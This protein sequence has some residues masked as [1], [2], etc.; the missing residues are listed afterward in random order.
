MENY[1]VPHR[2]VL[3]R[4]PIDGITSNRG[5]TQTATA[6]SADSWQTSVAR[7]LVQAPVERNAVNSGLKPLVEQVTLS[8]EG[9]AATGLATT[10]PAIDIASIEEAEKPKNRLAAGRAFRR[11][12]LR[13]GLIIFALLLGVGGVLFAQGYSKVH[14]VFK[15]TAGHAAALQAHVDPKLLKGE[16]DGRVNILL[17]GNGG[18]GHDAPDLTDTLLV[19]S[20]DPVNKTATLLSIPRDLWVQVPNYGSMKINAAYEV[21]KYNYL[22]KIDASNN[23]TKAVQAGFALADQVVESVIGIPIH[24]NALV[25]FT[26]FKQA[27]DSVG[28][29]TVN[30]PE[31]LYDPTMAWENG[32]NPVLA[33]AG[34]QPMDGK[35]AL[36]Y[37]RSRET[38][39]D[40]ARS[41]R[42][43][44][45]ILALKDKVLSAGTLSN[46][47]K[48]S[49][50]MN[51]F[52]NNMVTDI[53]LS[54]ASR[55]YAIMKTISNDHIQ[56]LDLVTPPHNLI[57]TANMNGVSIDQP[58]AGLFQ[59][60]DVQNFVRSAL[61]DGYLVNENAQI[62]VLNGTKVP[63]LAA[64]K[65]D[66]L[67]TYG[68]NVV[69]VDNAPEQ[70]YDKTVVI[71]LTNGASKYTKHYLEN[72]YGV[73]SVSQLP[74]STIQP[75][76]A[77][78]IIILGNDQA[79]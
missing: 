10:W 13:G 48:I 12:L 37:V 11:W 76:T 22:G 4:Q 73:T 18:S 43:R 75:G 49:Q 21:G 2:P 62:T 51:A 25:N 78:F 59:Y 6:R 53:S 41:Q 35:K 5:Q 47:I 40:F 57:T 28:G 34:T 50:L 66:E 72:R 46:P 71:D 3:P 45:V 60:A 20:I 74:G 64:K 67:R 54:D 70:T 24:Y 55:A 63:G 23:N 15:G 69:K 39:S 61:K 42:Q 32:N 68:Y 65:A 19:E 27:V 9:P 33:A 1:R 36:L 44:S 7:Q 16:G 29:I 8:A 17:L 58:R 14:K 30:V 52:G 77:N 56:S 31:A 38:S 26:S 79:Q